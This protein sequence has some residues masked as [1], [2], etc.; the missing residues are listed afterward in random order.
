MWYKKSHPVDQQQEETQQPYNQQETANVNLQNLISKAKGMINDASFDSYI[1]QAAQ[2][3]SNNGLTFSEK[4]ILKEAK[5]LAKGSWLGDK[6]ALDEIT[7]TINQILDGAPMASIEDL[8]RRK[9][10]VPK[11]N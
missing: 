7:N 5:D 1:E 8:N 6:G 2:N 11:I 10:V 9:L 3:L 4:D